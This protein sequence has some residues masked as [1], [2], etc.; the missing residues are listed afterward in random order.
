MA[1]L[2]EPFRASCDRNTEAMSR[3]EESSRWRE[4]DLRQSGLAEIHQGNLLKTFCSWHYSVPGKRKK[5]NTVKNESVNKTYL[6]NLLSHFSQNHREILQTSV[7]VPGSVL[8]EREKIFRLAER[9]QTVLQFAL[10]YS[11][12]CLDERFSSQEAASQLGLDDPQVVAA[13]RLPAFL[14]SVVAVC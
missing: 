6:M 8:I 5:T 12:Y 11:I 2:T 1:L 9:L 13:A 4:C 7:K 3:P 10:I 14:Q